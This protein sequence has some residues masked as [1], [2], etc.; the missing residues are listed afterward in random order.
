MEIFIQIIKVWS[1]PNS[2][3]LPEPTDIKNK[4]GFNPVSVTDN[5]L[6]IGVVAAE[7]EP[8]T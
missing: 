7:T 3:W 6:K 5:K 8:N 1:H 2:R 4:Y